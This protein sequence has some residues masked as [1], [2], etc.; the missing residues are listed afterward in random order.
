MLID[1]QHR[2]VGT[3]VTVSAS[4]QIDCDARG[5]I[6]QRAGRQVC[7]VHGEKRSEASGIHRERC[8]PNPLV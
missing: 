5:L 1:P 3:N 4:T 8:E 7:V 6:S 2:C